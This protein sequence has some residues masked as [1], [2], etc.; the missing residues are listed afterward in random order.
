[1]P[2]FKDSQDLQ[3]QKYFL[4]NASF[5]VA[6]SKTYGITNQDNDEQWGQQLDGNLDLAVNYQHKLHL[7]IKIT[8][9]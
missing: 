5:S 9:L 8:H 3:E 4:V 1:M 2:N 7:K 6:N